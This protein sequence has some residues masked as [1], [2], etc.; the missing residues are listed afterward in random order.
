MDDASWGA[1]DP[2]TM[3]HASTALSALRVMHHAESTT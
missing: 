2:V 1:Q 3:P